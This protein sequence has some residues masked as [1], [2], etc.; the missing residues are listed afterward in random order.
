VRS[1]AALWSADSLP[2]TA[3][4]LYRLG[5]I[6]AVAYIVIAYAIRFAHHKLTPTAAIRPNAKFTFDLSMNA[7]A[8]AT[9]FLLA[10]AVLFP[11][12]LKLLDHMQPFL[13]SAAIVGLLYTLNGLFE[14]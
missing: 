8:F 7:F 13:M 14:A 9:S 10:L 1:P 11:D 5:F 3:A 4:E 2:T 6:A 12:L